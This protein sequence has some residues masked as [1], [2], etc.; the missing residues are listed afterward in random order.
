[1]KKI[2][3]CLVLLVIAFSSWGIANV[4]DLRVRHYGNNATRLVM[5]LDSKAFYSIEPSKGGNALQI[6]LRETALNT[7]LPIL[8]SG[9]IISDLRFSQAANSSSFTLSA[10]KPISHLSMVLYSPYRI[11][12]DVFIQNPRSRQ[13]RLEL[14]EFFAHTGRL[15]R[16]ESM[17][18]NL[19][20]SYPNDD[21]ILLKWG[22]ILLEAKD[23]DRAKQK[24]NQI[25]NS[26]EHYQAAQSLLRG[27]Q[28]PSPQKSKT[29]ASPED[30]ST[31]TL[32]PAPQDS[33]IV[34]PVPGKTIS[35]SRP[36][37]DPLAFLARNIAA[38]KLIGFAL[39]VVL[40]LIILIKSG[41]FKRRNTSSQEDSFTMKDDDKPE[42][43]SPGL[44]DDTMARMVNRLAH[45]GWKPNEIALELGI[46]AKEAKRLM[47]TSV[48]D[49][50]ENA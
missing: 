26:S 23:I 14:V 49:G 28:T 29:V 42:E 38:L 36:K 17:L 33:T 6:E 34:T 40:I 27:T 22:S 11:V 21:S 16:A 37:P 10:S 48:S 25:S 8:G 45:D 15:E 20:K 50:S 9:Y 5:E 3:L 12:V 13:E 39:L 43:E 19:Q 35:P 18:T 31:E 7:E 44:D 2:T 30:K 47:R 32:V 41:I 46:S 24:L 1:M 4:S